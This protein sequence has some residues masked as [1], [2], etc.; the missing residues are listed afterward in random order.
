MAQTIQSSDLGNNNQTQLDQQNQGT[1]QQAGQNP[2]APSAGASGAGT[3]NQTGSGQSGGGGYQQQTG[4]ANAQAASYNPNKQQGSGYT[5]IQKVLNANQ[6][7]QLGQ[8]VGSGI[9][10]QTNEAQQNLNQ[11]QQQF[12]QQTTANQAN[13]GDNSALVQNVLG[14]TAQYAPGGANAAQGQQFQQLISGQYGGP[15]QLANQQQLQN[16]A[17]NVA[18][19]GQATG[20]QA[21]QMGLLQRF[22]GNPQYTQGQQGLDQLLLGQ[23]GQPQL[24][25]ARR[26][27]LQLQGQVNSGITGAQATGQQQQNQAQQF[28]QNVQQQLGQTVQGINTGLQNQA[29]TA[30]QGSNKNY[31]D[32]LAALKSGNINQQQADLLGLKNGE[33]VTTNGLN[34]IGNFL[35]QNPNQATAQNVASG[36]NYAQLDAL[37]QL[38]GN[39]APQSAQNTLQQYAGQNANANQFQN[40]QQLTADQAG[41]NAANTA[42]VNDYNSIVNPAA[43]RQQQALAVQKLANEEQQAASPNGNMNNAQVQALQQQMQQ[44]S[45]GAVYNGGTNVN[46]ANTQADLAGRAEDAALTNARNAYGGLQTI[47]ITPQQAALQ[48][49]QAQQNA[50]S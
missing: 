35:T 25:A 20:S 33:Q 47:N 49:I 48:Q 1:Q 8:A 2:P 6:G 34:S 3:G 15:T 17:S 12:Q 24:A 13:T 7:N 32:T 21:G 45:P 5:N 27:A 16:Q 23:T 37:R 28:G 38:G 31:A 36:Q 46:W 11:G 22:V 29:A 9:Q 44:L 41:F 14:N 50:G 10:N 30:Q 43:Q 39:F 42:S 18:Q 40:Q 26:G 19:L 4:Q